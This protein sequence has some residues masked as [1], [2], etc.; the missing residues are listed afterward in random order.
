LRRVFSVG[1]FD[2]MEIM[3]DMYT[4]TVGE[5]TG[6]TS[7]EKPADIHTKLCLLANRWVRAPYSSSNPL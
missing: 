3:P 2:L 4:G 1:D 5:I 7:V 6:G